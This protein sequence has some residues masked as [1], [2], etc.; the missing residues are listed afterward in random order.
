MSAVLYDALR[1]A[2]IPIP[3][4]EVT[5][6]R[7]TRWGK[8]K[9]FYAIQLS[10]GSGYYFGNFKDQD[11]GH[12]VFENGKKADQKVIEQARKKILQNQKNT[13]EQVSENCTKYWPTMPQ[14]NEHPYLT[15][16]RIKSH[17]LRGYMDKIVIPLQD[18]DGKIWSLQYIA[19]DGTKHFRSGGRKNGCFCPFGDFFNPSK[20]FICE[21]Y[22]TAATVFENTNVPTVVAFDAG[23]LYSVTEAIRKKYHDAQIVICADND[24]YGDVNTGVLK[25][26]NAANKFGCTV[27]YPTFKDTSTKPTDFNDLFILEGTEAV[28]KALATPSIQEKLTNS[29]G[30]LN[31]EKGLFYYDVKL[32][33]YV[34]ICAP[35]EVSALTRELEEE[36]AGHLLQFT[37]RNN[38]VQQVKIFDAW[39]AKDGSKIH[40]AL[41]KR[42]F[43]ID[44]SI[45]AKNK[46]NEFI[47]NSNPD[48]LITYTLRSG[49]HDK[50][51]LTADESFGDN[52]GSL[53]HIPAAEPAKISFSG[54]LNDWQTNISTLCCGNS[55]L[56]LAV[57][58]AF[59][60]MILT[61]CSA[62]SFFLHFYG[63]SS[64][65]KTTLLDV[66]ASVFGD[67]SYTRT[68]RMTDNGLEGIAMAHNDLC[69]FLD[70]ISECD[71]Y[72]IGAMSYMLVNGS[73]KT[74]A[75]TS[76][77]ARRVM[78]WKLGGV[79]TGEE[80][81][82]DIIKTTG[83]TPKA[84]QLLRVLSIPAI[85]DGSPFGVF[86]DIHDFDSPADFSTHLKNAAQM[87]HGIAFRAFIEAVVK[88]YDN[89]CLFFHEEMMKATK[90]FLPLNASGQDNRAF[91][92]FAT[93]GI[94][95][96]LATKYGIT[97]W[98]ASDLMRSIM[99]NFEAWL[100]N[101]NGI[102]NQKEKQIL[103]Q[104]RLFFEK[105]GAS[106]FQY[107]S[108]G[109]PSYDRPPSERAGYR[110]RRS[111]E[112]LFYVFKSYFEE[113][114]AR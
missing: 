11:N 112:L 5:T 21:G 48:K 113:V 23:N 43:H 4:Q 15:K 85:P 88:D 55:R 98:D 100:Q 101:K 46:L 45:K 78:R 32:K 82:S 20:I 62:D 17:G 87:Y 26:T 38:A 8:N 10:D 40:D 37:D 42:G 109:M 67:H 53:V 36:N 84:G 13:H 12:V 54:D 22:A 56:L 96:L 90:E 92:V 29:T 74:R 51:F 89:I 77:S 44:T 106:R 31:N 58:A 6:A 57:S 27:V 35:L 34:K 114:I 24:A 18:A 110:T 102:G 64:Q 107:I 2:G 1:T 95:G 75:N 59:A 71:A 16:K 80:Q 63:A 93:C 69:L 86:E 33:D 73:G 108:D 30:F 41:Y 76:G 83:K 91:R 103:S 99:L 28:K 25:A 97:G 65:G 79:S 47:N 60:S 104:I 14:I 52:D 111:G 105:Y 72:K 68:W 66:G 3:N 50:I 19:P 9:E 81:L 7:Y 70:E 39:L 61:P 49:W 94:A